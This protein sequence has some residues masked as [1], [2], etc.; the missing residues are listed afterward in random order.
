MA[1]WKLNYWPVNYC[2]RAE[3]ARLVFEE[4]GVQYEDSKESEM[5]F[6]VSTFAKKEKTVEGWPTFAPP[7]LENKKTGFRLSQTPVICE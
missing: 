5:D 4:A 3:F 1:E 2:G 7:F 6:Y